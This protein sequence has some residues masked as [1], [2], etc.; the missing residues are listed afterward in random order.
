MSLSNF[1]SKFFTSKKPNKQP[2]HTIWIDVRSK[3]E[4][5]SGSVPMAQNIPLDQIINQISI[6]P[7]DKKIMVFCTNGNRS[8]AAKA[9]L[10]RN[11]FTNVQDAG[12]MEQILA[13]KFF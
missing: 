8:K 6:L 11:G 3:G 10:E 5:A 1:I 4:F 2:A 12:A 7:K 13:Q 9:I